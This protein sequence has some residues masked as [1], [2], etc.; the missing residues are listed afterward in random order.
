M[1]VVC[2]G[3]GV[4]LSMGKGLYRVLH[5]PADECVLSNSREKAPHMIFLEVLRCE[6]K[7][8]V[9]FAPPTVDLL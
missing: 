9:W 4:V 5:I 6:T 1:V 2:W 8:F 7:R 3:A